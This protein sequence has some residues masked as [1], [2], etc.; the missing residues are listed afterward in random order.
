MYVWIAIHAVC[1]RTYF[2]MDACAP[3]WD[4]TSQPS[5]SGSTISVPHSP[6]SANPSSPTAI[7]A[8]PAMTTGA[9]DTTAAVPIASPDADGSRWQRGW[10]RRWRRAIPVAVVALQFREGAES[11]RWLLQSQSWNVLVG[12]PLRCRHRTHQGIQGGGGCSVLGRWESSPTC[13]YLCVIFFLN[14]I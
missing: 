6:L 11:H 14:P 1:P 5:R 13:A 7:G 2:R 3:G 10:R 9:R 4:D 8:A 12:M